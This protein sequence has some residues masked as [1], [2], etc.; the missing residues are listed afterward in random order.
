MDEHSRIFFADDSELADFGAACTLETAQAGKTASATKTAEAQAV[1]NER[2]AKLASM[3]KGSTALSD[4]SAEIRREHDLKSIGYFERAV[5][6]H[7]TI[8]HAD[9]AEQFAKRPKHSQSQRRAGILPSY[10][11]ARITPGSATSG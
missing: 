5:I 4:D 3:H 2:H 6:E 10:S 11:P 9:A 8:D 1:S 7:G